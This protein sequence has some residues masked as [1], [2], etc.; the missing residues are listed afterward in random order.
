[1][2]T[3]RKLLAGAAWSYG[4]QFITVVAQFVYAAVTSRAVGAAGFGAYSVALAASGLVSLLVMAG[5]GQ[6]VSRMVDLEKGR[7]VALV[8]Y[9]I[10]LGGGAGALLLLVAP[11]WSWLWGVQSAT[12]P[13]RWLAIST[14]ISPLFAL[15]TGLMARL[16]KFRQLAVITLCCNLAGMIVGTAAV[17][18]WKSS[19]S[20]IV[21]AALAQILTF[22]CA[23]FA[24]DRHLFGVGPLRHGR[25]EIGYSGKLASTSVLSYTT[26]NL[27]KFSMAKGIDAAS[28]GFW[29]RAEVLTLVPM[30]QVQGAIIRAVSP[31]FRHDVSESTRARIVWTDL[32]IVVAWLSLPIGGVAY[33]VIPPLVPILFGNGWELAASVSGPLA[34]AGALQ[35]L[36]TLLA[37]AVEALGRFRWILSTETLLIAVQVIFAVYVLLKHDIWFAVCALLATNVVRHGWH[38]WLLARRGY[39]DARRLLVNYAIAAVFAGALAAGV[40]FVLQLM[41]FRDVPVALLIGS[42][43]VAGAAIWACFRLRNRLPVVAIARRYGLVGRVG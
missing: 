27:I 43:L 42:L 18:T 29:N 30:Q 9:A 40:W 5:L 37:T 26:G 23:M 39:L 12:E 11:W 17:L 4:A 2:T 31:E 38:I 1:M 33:V 8:T 28:L 41:T 35:I 22:A 14:S 13:I 36:S 34:V 20:L 3:A 24:T 16:G 25:A 7:L 6:S 10:L 32:L 19:S 21:S 15:A